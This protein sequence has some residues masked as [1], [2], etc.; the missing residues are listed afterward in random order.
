MCN[1]ESQVSREEKSKLGAE[2]EML[3]P[4][5]RDVFFAPK[6]ST[7]TY[8]PDNSSTYKSAAASQSP[9]PQRNT[10]ILSGGLRAF[11]PAQLRAVVVLAFFA[12]RVAAVRA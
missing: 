6:T 9:P 11:A 1:A 3:E 2:C 12:G 4:A 10:V 8:R 5:T 7:I